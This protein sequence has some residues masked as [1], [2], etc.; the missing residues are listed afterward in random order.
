MT[1][2]K[3]SES[4]N[5]NSRM[6]GVTLVELIIVVAII[7]ILSAIAFPN[8]SKYQQRA[9][10]TDAKSALQR[11]ATNQE[12]FYVSNFS[13]TAD[14]AQL[15]FSSNESE[16]GFYMISVL[17]ADAQ[18]FQAVAI[19]APGSSQTNDSDCQQFTIDGQSVV[20]AIPDPG[21]KCW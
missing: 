3:L 4:R 7:A 19:P 20:G 2:I 5:T 12:R 16:S 10:R 11:I 17:A 9:R 6:C 1:K 15:G 14:L 13:Y 8:F 18:G 21:G